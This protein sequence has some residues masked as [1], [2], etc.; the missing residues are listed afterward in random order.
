MEYTNQWYVGGKNSEGD[1]LKVNQTFGSTRASAY[2]IY[3]QTLNLQTVTIRDPVKYTDVNG[4]E[5][6]KYVIN[7]KETMIARGKQQE[8]RDAFK[9]WLFADKDRAESLLKLYNDK[10]NNVVPRSYDGSHLIFPGMS[11]EEE[12]RPHQ[13]N[14]AAR[15]IYNGTAL[16]AHEVGRARRRP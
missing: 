11:D 10:F 9:S 15:I 1:N 14:V 8:I 16:M 5:K 13:L 4:K 12:L 7:A 3:E 2:E 6:T